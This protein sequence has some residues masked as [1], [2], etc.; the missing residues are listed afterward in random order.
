MFRHIYTF[1]WIK[2]CYNLFHE[3]PLEFVCQHIVT[4][5]YIKNSQ[6][7]KTKIFKKNSILPDKDT[8]HLFYYIGLF[9]KLKIL[10][11]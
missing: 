6:G 1:I 10:I 8:C 7:N 5:I 4:D 2:C 9:N 3:R 11:N